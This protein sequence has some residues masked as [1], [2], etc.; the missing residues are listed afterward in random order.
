MQPGKSR[1]CMYQK[2]LEPPMSSGVLHIVDSRTKQK[3][4]IPIRRNVISAIDLKSIKA[5]AAGTDRAD[6]VADGLRVHDPGLQNTTVIESAISYSYD[7]G[8][9]D[10]VHRLTFVVIMKEVYFS[11]TVTHCPNYGTAI[12]KTCYIYSSGEHIHQCNRRRT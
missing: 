7:K 11:F 9:G 1:Y 4:E 3:Y 2:S 12:S 6:H 5:P 8:Q 10:L